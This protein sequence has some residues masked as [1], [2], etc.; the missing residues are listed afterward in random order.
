MVKY[1]KQNEPFAFKTSRSPVTQLVSWEKWGA[2]REAVRKA[3][4]SDR[5]LVLLL[6]GEVVAKLLEGKKY[7]TKC[8]QPKHLLCKIK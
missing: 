7:W 6:A 1:L 2:Q 4:K 8:R 5:P 3:N